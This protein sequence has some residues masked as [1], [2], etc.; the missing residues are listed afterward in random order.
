MIKTVV[1]FGGSG[2][3]GGYIVRRLSKLGFRIIIPT[4]SFNKANKLKIMGNVGQILPISF[5]STKYE[6]VIKIING[7]D[8]VINLKT[9]WKE[10]NN[11]TYVNNIYNL[12]KSIVDSIIKL[13]IKKYVYFSGIG[14]DIKESSK[15]I[16]SIVNSEKYIEKF[17]FNYSIIKPSI[18]IGDESKFINRLLNI[19]RFSFFIPIFGKGD[20][21][22]QPVFV[23]DIALAVEKIVLKKNIY[24]E[25]YELGGKK[26][27]SY[28]E[29]YKFIIK[30]IGKKRI[31]VKIPFSIAKLFVFLMEKLH[32]DL[33]NREQLELFKKDNLVGKKSLTFND[34]E[35]NAVDVKQIV[36]KIINNS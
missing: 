17:L 19:F 11:K 15:R 27:F 36:K 31:I 21:K 7:A 29:F 30:E 32:I 33:L 16:I 14:T 1:I 28:K 13:K 10:K 26:V 6:D 22:F 20:T 23:D 34:L 9:I 3:I 24:K 4:S 2:F 5:N 8:Y 18:V 35:I 12:N 25:I